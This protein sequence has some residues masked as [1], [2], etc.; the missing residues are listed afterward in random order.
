MRVLLVVLLTLSPVAAR[1]SNADR[2]DAIFAPFARTD[3][4][5]CVVGVY[6]S[7]EIAFTGAYG[8]ADVAHRVPLRDTT[9]MSLAS[10]TKTFTALAVLLLEADGKIRLGDDIRRYVPEVPDFGTP[11]TLLDLLQHTSGLRDYWN[12]FNMAGWRHSDVETLD[13][14][15]WL[16]GR[17]RGLNH[18]TGAEFLYTNT[19]YILLAVMVERVSGTSFRSFL[20]N[21]IFEPLGMPDSDVKAEMSQVVRGLATGYWGHDPSSLRL[22]TR[23]YSFAGNGGVMTTVR[24]LARW[25][26]NF[27]EPKVGTKE[28]LDSM[29][30]PGHV[31]DGTAFGY[32]LG[33]FIG[34]HRGHR[35][36]SHAGSD[37]GSKAEFIRFPDDRLSV[38][39]LCNAWDI[40]PTPLALQVADLYLQERTAP[41]QD[42]V[43][44]GGAPE[45]PTESMA[46]LYWHAATGGL[47]RLLVADGQLKL[48]GGGEGIFPLK[49]LG[50]G[51]YRLTAAPRKYVLTFVKNALEVNVEGSPVRTYEKVPE[52]KQVGPLSELAGTYRSEELDVEWTIALRSGQ[53]ILER[54]RIGTD[55]LKR[56]FGDVFQSEGGYVIEFKRKPAALE[57]I[58]ERVRRLRFTRMPPR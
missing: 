13:D 56:L 57:V 15:L 20:S 19:G 35:M 33:F 5:G 34:T 8:M 2:I 10:A 43:A 42:A 51:A 23:P 11:I 49:S 45:I 1:D 38:A 30:V 27:N 41:V 26:A 37:P 40:A 3:A 9:A 25:D 47:T 7:G 21:R 32:G 46:G 52:T 6:R 55:P 28:M 12:L 31:K 18:P 14:V 22:A 50:H 48:D 53:L 4:P 39:V 36:I 44:E 54:R 16:V 29:A 24:D 58:T 17:Q